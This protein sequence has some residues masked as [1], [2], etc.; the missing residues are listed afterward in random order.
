MRNI[1][2]PWKLTKVF[3][4]MILSGWQ[5]YCSGREEGIW[6]RETWNK[7]VVFCAYWWS[8]N[9][10]SPLEN[11]LLT[12]FYCGFS[13]EPQKCGRPRVCLQTLDRLRE[14]CSDSN[15]QCARARE[16]GFQGKESLSLE[17]CPSLTGRSSELK[18]PS[19]D[20]GP[21]VTQKVCRALVCGDCLLW[22][23][24]ASF[25]TSSLLCKNIV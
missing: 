18:N 8:S 9:R 10:H 5:K 12:Y 2:F 11:E 3:K 14:F 19:W 22:V 13:P 16:D 21:K 7:M 4:C 17:K 1:G 23:K 25:G 20:T 24:P 15:Q 6:G